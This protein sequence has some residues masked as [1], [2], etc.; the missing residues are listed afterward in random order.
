MWGAIFKRKE[1]VGNVDRQNGA[2]RLIEGGLLTIPEAVQFLGLS[3]AKVYQLMDEGELVYAKI[4]KA[5]RIP[6]NALID[7]VAANLKG[8]WKNG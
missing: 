2:T 5:R 3:R 7:F 4:G 1:R 8:G 6:R